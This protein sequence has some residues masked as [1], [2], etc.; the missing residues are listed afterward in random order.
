MAIWN[1][2]FEAT[3]AGSDSPS[4]GDDRIRE[5]KQAVRERLIKEH[6]MDLSSGAAAADGWHAAGSAK[7]YVGS[8]AP[9]T[10]PD[11]ATTLT[12]DDDGRLWLSSSDFQLRAY[13]HAAGTTADERWEVISGSGG[14]SENFL[15][16][17]LTKPSL[18]AVTAVGANSLEWDDTAT[19]LLQIGAL[20]ADFLSAGTGRYIDMDLRDLDAVEVGR[21][22]WVEFAYKLANNADDLVTV[23]LYDGSV[24]IPLNMTALPY[25]GGNTQVTGAAV[26]PTTVTT[27]LKLRFKIK[28]STAVTLYLADARVGPQSV[29]VGAAVGATQTYP[30]TIG[31]TT[32]PPT[33]GT[34]AEDVATWARRGD[35]ML[36]SYR[37]K[38]TAAGSAGSGVYL[39]PLP[40]GYSI[41][42]TK[43][44]AGSVVG[45][46]FASDQSGLETTI[47]SGS[48]SVRVYDAT[49]L[50]ADM[51]LPT[52]TTNDVLAI[53]SI[54]AQLSMATQKYSYIAEV[55]IADWSANV[56]LASDFQEFAFNTQATVNTNDTTSFGYGSG[57][58]AILSNTATTYYDVAF[59]RSIQPTD[60]IIVEVRDKAT[61]IWVPSEHAGIP[62]LFVS[63]LNQF[64]RNTD[65]SIHARGIWF[66]G[67]ATN[68]IRVYFGAPL[69]GGTNWSSGFAD[70]TWAS[71]TAAADGYDRWRVRKVSGGN[72]AEVPPVVYADYYTTGNQSANTD[73]KYLNRLSDTHN[74]YNPSTGIFTAPIAGVYQVCAGVFASGL[75]GTFALYVGG[76]IQRALAIGN[77]GT[78]IIG[79]TAI[80][81]AQGDQLSTRFTQASSAVVDKQIGITI[82]RIGS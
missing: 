51:L 53:S 2:A 52:Q 37:Y 76:V 25:A 59:K 80:R 50:Y 73:I 69:T 27:G 7:V 45:S 33:K 3:P 34:V 35:K 68:K 18:A 40:A 58:A 9:T 49:R 62:S 71:I 23:Y 10:R 38:Q 17:D 47:T 12:A 65:G 77:A 36:L 19:T 8:T 5:L 11:G 61:G 43:H 26:L 13:R 79:S 6:E 57:G 82:A 14:G 16:N 72:S 56:N 42:L 39:F 46:F 31:A 24:E 67:V 1:S 15:K 60:N 74:A 21:A 81:L 20:K 28:D 64:Y 54:T 48:G 29:P 66:S 41:D 70:R 63:T 30:L 55:T 4:Q 75:A 22:W 32:T 78:F 44:P